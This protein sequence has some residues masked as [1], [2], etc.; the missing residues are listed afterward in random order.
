V[1]WFTIINIMKCIIRKIFL[2]LLL[3]IT[4]NAMDLL[5]TDEEREYISQNPT[6]KVSNEL[7]WYPYDFNVNGNADGYAVDYFKLL[8]GK[9][10][11]HVVFVSDN[12]SNQK[13][14]FQSKDI[15]ILYPARKT[16]QRKEKY[17][18]SKEFLKMKLSLVTKT[19]LKNINSIKDMIGKKIAVGR[20]WSSTTYLK[21]RYKNIEFIEFDTS[22]EVLEAVAFGLTDGGID[23]FF[24]SNYLMKSEMLANLHI[25]SQIEINGED[26]YS[27]Y[28]LF[29]KDK[30]ILQGLFDRAIDSV[31]EYELLKMK[32]KWLAPLSKV[33]KSVI[34]TLKESIY[35]KN[36]KSISMCVDPHW[37]PLEMIKDGLHVGISSDYM[38]I[39]EKKLG[40]PIELVA[41]KTWTESL[42]LAKK[43]ECDILS[44]AMETPKR[45]RYLDFTTSYLDIPLVMI[46]KL[47]KVLY[48]DIKNL[49]NEPIG[50]PKDYAYGEILRVKYPQL[51]FVDVE[52]I[53]EGLVKVENGEIFGFIDSLATAGY[54][55]KNRYFGTL[56]IAA[57]L[58]EKWEL[59]IATRND[60][61]I[62]FDIFDKIIKSIDKKVDQ[63]I[64]SRWISVQYDKKTDYT[65]LYLLFLLLI[66]VGAFVFYRQHQLKKH[67]R[68]LEILSTTDTLTGIYNRLKLDDVMLYEKNLFD[69]FNRPLSIILLDIDDFK[70]VNDKY[71]HKVGDEVLQDIAKIILKS[72]RK[73][74]ILG[75][76]GGEEFLVICHE[77]DLQGASELAEKFRKAVYSYSFSNAQKLSAS[78]GVAEFENAESIEKVFIKA[79]TG[80][81]MA[82]K[83]GKNR[84]ESI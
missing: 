76:W 36:K 23:D 73:T 80:L 12:W 77:T 71:G 46:T 72:K 62:L 78:F 47:D 79:D 25:A 43:R 24:T 59:G 82:K 4:L 67:N 57:K 34:F 7:G 1:F 17:L 50:I 33:K 27:L 14:K 41:T 38:K 56:K 83:S 20:G 26:S 48:S 9:I 37:M 29:H 2:L 49:I 64:L 15:D 68:E 21:K 3:G 66:I 45:K 60:E 75:R 44:L 35:L 6:I 42:Q 54:M 39:F 84:V 53:H 55:I 19:Q 65:Y 51:D 5:L 13:K 16:P 22:K 18:F 81:Y 69:R 31:K 40:I 74:D 61:P 30:K 70:K 11:L 28:L 8:A 32:I 52:N 58:D 10:G 63:E